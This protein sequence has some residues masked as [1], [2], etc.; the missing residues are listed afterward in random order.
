MRP[1]TDRATLGRMEN[2]IRGILHGSAAV[3]SL[4]GAFLLCARCS[5]PL[6]RVALGVFAASLVTL[7]T[8]SSL[9]HSV[10]WRSV[11][12]ARMQRLDHCMIYLLVAGTYTPLAC[13]VLEGWP[14]WWGL[15]AAWSIAFLGILQ[16]VLLPRVGDWFSI[17]MQTLQGWLALPLLFPLAE[18]LGYSALVLMG[19]GGVFY[20]VGMVF[21]VTERPRLW[22]R[23]FS[24]HE[25]FHVL[26]IAGSAAHYSVMFAYVSRFA[27]A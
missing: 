19:L 5:D 6:S 2:P 10:P 8:A 14:R 18:K 4:I 7:Y 22:P 13:I 26:V 11:W 3:A 20:T 21:L 17:T 15:G 9:Y 1:T 23:V 25:A 16:K 12:K 24:Y 27:A